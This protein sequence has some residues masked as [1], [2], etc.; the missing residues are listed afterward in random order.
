MTITLSTICYLKSDGHVKKDLIFL[1]LYW[2]N[3]YHETI[4][5]KHK[6]KMRILID[7]LHFVV[8]QSLSNVWLCNLVGC[9]KPGFPVLHHLLELAP[10]HVHWV[11]DT[12]QPSLS[13]VAPF[14]SC[15][16]SFPASGSFPMS[17]F[18]ASG[19]QSIGASA[20][21]SVLLMNI[22]DWFPLGW[23]D[24]ISF[25][26]KGLLPRVF[27]NTTAQKHQFF[28]IPLSQPFILLLP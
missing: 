13:S 28:S 11:S 19:C 10:T 18:F 21:T 26:F 16:Q 20:S 23:T 8:V 9:S 7:V 15:L 14:S 4:I 22:Q 5:C 24:L 3:D 25:Q 27:S 1:L 2:L 6:H 17:Q 12:I